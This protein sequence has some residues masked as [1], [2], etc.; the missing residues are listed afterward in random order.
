[1]ENPVFGFCFELIFLR[2][3]IQ[4]NNNFQIKIKNDKKAQK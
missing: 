1:M 2:L 3:E 4:K